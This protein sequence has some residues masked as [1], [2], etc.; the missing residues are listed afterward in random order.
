M[1]LYYTHINWYEDNSRFINVLGTNYFPSLASVFI[2]GCWCGPC[3]LYVEL[4]VMCC[5]FIS[6]CPGSCLPNVVSVSG[7][8]L[9]FS[10]TFIY[11]TE[12]HKKSLK[13]HGKTHKWLAM[14]VLVIWGI[15]DFSL[16][17]KNV[18]HSE[19]L[20]QWFFQ[21]ITRIKYSAKIYRVSDK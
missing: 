12:Q 16:A 7:L 17:L 2:P 4:S 6:L 9:Q 20:L 8:P 19:R 21:W 3:C 11:Y 14:F 18:E 13:Y 5:F 10:L 15:H 1:T